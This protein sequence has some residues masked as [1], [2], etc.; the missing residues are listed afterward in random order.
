[1]GSIHDGVLVTNVV[2]TFH[3]YIIHQRETIVL[4]EY[5]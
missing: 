3:Q 1:M 5:H 4:Y 2:L